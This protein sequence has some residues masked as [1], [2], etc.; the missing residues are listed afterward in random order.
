MFAVQST[1]SLEAYRGRRDEERQIDRPL[2]GVL[3]VAR[4]E[5]DAAAQRRRG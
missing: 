4:I 1:V 5:S 3:C 2:K